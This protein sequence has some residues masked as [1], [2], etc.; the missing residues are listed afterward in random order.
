MAAYNL[1]SLPP[2]RKYLSLIATNRMPLK[3]HSTAAF[4]YEALSS[5]GEAFSLVFKLSKL[6]TITS[7]SSIKLNR[8]PTFFILRSSLKLSLYTSVG[9]LELLKELSLVRFNI[10]LC[11]KASVALNLRVGFTQRQPDI[12]EIARI[13]TG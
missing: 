6:C 7:A 5:Q 9:R 2:R 4:V 3:C 8:L 12:D 13:I 10:Q 11:V 1:P